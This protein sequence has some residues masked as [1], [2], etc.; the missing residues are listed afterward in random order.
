MGAPPDRTPPPLSAADTDRVR[1]SRTFDRVAELYDRARPE[2]PDELFEALIAAAALRPGDSLLEVGSGTGRA[3]LPLARRGF[4]V[5]AIEPGH[6]LAV[7]AR[8][9]L[10]KFD[11]SVVETAFEDWE[12]DGEYAL[13]FAATSWHWIDPAVK[14]ARAWQVLRPGGHLALWSASHVFPDGGDDFFRRIQPVYDEIGEGMP[15]GTPCP[16]PDELTDDRT[17]IEASGLFEVVDLRYF[18]WE[19]TYDADGYIELL[20]SFSGHISMQHWQR[21]RLFGEIRDRLAE[22][23]DGLLRRHWGAVL[24]VARRR[25]S[26]DVAVSATTR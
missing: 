19:R 16:R 22:R 26:P 7:L 17:D 3:T 25:D 14:Y 4:A 5:T 24:Q 15:P 21:A 6:N 13:V 10:E 18:D 1:L 12:A 20:E 11:V 2:Y 23:P 8:R 9:N